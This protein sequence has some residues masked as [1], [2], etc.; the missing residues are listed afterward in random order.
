MRGGGYGL[1]VISTATGRLNELGRRGWGYGE[2]I[3]ACGRDSTRRWEAIL[4]DGGMCGCECLR[5]RACGGGG[6]GVG[7]GGGRCRA[8]VE[9][10]VRGS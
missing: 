4:D 3:C 8:R 10:V 9:P 1:R 7:A 6:G 5:S 2:R